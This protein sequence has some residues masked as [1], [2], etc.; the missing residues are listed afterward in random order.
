VQSVLIRVIRG[1]SLF[2]HQ[3]G[4]IVPFII[5]RPM[6]LFYHIFSKSKIAEFAMRDVETH[7]RF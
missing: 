2:V 6:S 7:G 1:Q 5:P 4:L 3:A